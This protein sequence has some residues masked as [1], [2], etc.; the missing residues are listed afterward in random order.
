MTRFLLLTFG[1]I[2]FYFLLAGFGTHFGLAYVHFHLPLLN[3][4][5]EAGRYLA[6]FTILTAFLAG[7]GLQAIM[8][9]ASRKF[10]LKGK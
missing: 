7:L 9:V 3:R 2:A 4:I 8:D 6:V 1:A 10:E 5:R